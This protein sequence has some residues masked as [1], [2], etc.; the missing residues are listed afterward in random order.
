MSR[1]PYHSNATLKR[2]GSGASRSAYFYVAR[3]NYAAE[4]LRAAIIFSLSSAIIVIKLLILTPR[5]FLISSISDFVKPIE[6]DYQRQNKRE[7][8]VL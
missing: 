5:D 4:I 6:I 8:I 3:R 2:R 7:A 1:Y